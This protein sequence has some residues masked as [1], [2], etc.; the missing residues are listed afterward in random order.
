MSQIK[1]STPNFVECRNKYAQQCVPFLKCI[2]FGYKAKVSFYFINFSLLLKTNM[3]VCYT[4]I[5]WLHTDKYI[6]MV[7]ISG[8]ILRIAPAEKLVATI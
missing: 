6:H 4:Q 1:F 3:P 2:S 8:Y 7:P 5:Q